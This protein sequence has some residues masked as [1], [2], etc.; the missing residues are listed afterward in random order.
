MNK[1]KELLLSWKETFPTGIHGSTF[2]L[3]HVMLLIETLLKS[4]DEEDK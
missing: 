3:K 2:S 4:I 1:T